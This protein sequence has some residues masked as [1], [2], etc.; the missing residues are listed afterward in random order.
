M[1]ASRGGAPRIQAFQ[2]RAGWQTRRAAGDV[3]EELG[4]LGSGA[5]S[6]FHG[7]VLPRLLAHRSISRLRKE[8]RHPFREALQSIVIAVM[9]VIRGAFPDTYGGYYMTVNRWCIQGPSCHRHG[10]R[11]RENG[12]GKRFSR[13]RDVH[14]AHDAD[15]RAYSK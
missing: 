4:T 3:L 6:L 5:A 8:C 1:A 11:H 13:Y 14:D 7:L 10:Y 2:S 12:L 9:S 15:I